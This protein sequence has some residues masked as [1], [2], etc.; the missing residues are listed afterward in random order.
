M[1]Y[2][3]GSCQGID[4]FWDKI[5]QLYDMG[6]T[7]PNQPKMTILSMLSGSYKHIKKSLIRHFLKTAQSVIARSCC[8]PEPP[9]L[10]AWA[11]ELKNIEY[12]E[13]MLL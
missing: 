8:W 13:S 11:C 5:L 3:W 2:I 12:M 6:D 10:A 7:Y 9:S 4:P 1:L